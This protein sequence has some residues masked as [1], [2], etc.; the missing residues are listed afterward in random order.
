MPTAAVDRRAV[1]GERSRG[2]TSGAFTS[3]AAAAAHRRGCDERAI[4]LGAASNAICSNNGAPALLRASSAALREKRQSASA[5]ARCPL[6]PTGAAWRG[7]RW[8]C[9]CRLRFL[10]S[11][12]S[13]CRVD[14]ECPD[15]DRHAERADE[16]RHPAPMRYFEEARE[17]WRTYVPARGQAATIQGELIRAVEKLRDEAQR[18]GNVN[19]RDDHAIHVNYL[20]DTLLGSGLFDA[21]AAREIERDTDRLLDFERPETSDEPYDRLTDRVVEWSRAHPDPVARDPNPELS[22]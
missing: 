16:S 20:R 15:R 13:K 3:R 12:R 4:P 1:R 11:R 6:P 10:G 2:S 9:H 17:L 21:A 8:R 5:W 22:I 19:W 7:P 14:H 18:N